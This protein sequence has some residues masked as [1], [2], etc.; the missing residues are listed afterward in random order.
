MKTIVSA[1]IALSVLTSVA[2]PASA[3]D[4]KGFYSGW[5]ATRTDARTGSRWLPNNLA[6]HQSRP[7][8]DLPAAA[9][10]LAKRVCALAIGPVR[11]ETPVDWLNSFSVTTRRALRRQTAHRFPGLGGSPD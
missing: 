7:P 5:I 2:A 3:F 8:P 11:R 1:L 9:S 6:Q 4:V 10:C